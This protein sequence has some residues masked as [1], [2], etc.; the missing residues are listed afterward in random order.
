MNDRLKTK[1]IERLYK[2]LAALDTADEIE[3]FFDDLCTVNEIR[4]LS[5]R[6]EIAR[7]LREKMPYTEIVKHTDSSTATITR[8]NHCLQYG[9]EGYDLALDK[10]GDE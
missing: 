6:L 7:L 9:S 10:L 5:Q 2:A 4:S 1:E 3:R 8:V